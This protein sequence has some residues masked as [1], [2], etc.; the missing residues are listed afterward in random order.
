MV[1]L[2]YA[3]AHSLN[4]ATVRLAVKL[5]LG[6]VVKTLHALGVTDKLPA[7]PSLALG[8]A[9]LSPLTMTQVYQ[10][11]AAGGFRSPL[12][13]IRAVTTQ[14]GRPLQ[15]YRLKAEAAADARAVYLTNTALQQV[16]KSGTARGLKRM[17]PAGMGA[18]G[19]T[20]TT[21]KLRDSW[22]AGFTSSRVAVV[23][24]GRDDNTPAGLTG[25]QGARSSRS[26]G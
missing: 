2:D 26:G 3:L 15:R 9:T 22:F 5:G 4:V 6:K 24:V 12:R 25:A 16:V 1:A 11:L 23:W 17:L 18:A 20:G 8:S 21:N 7:Y 19:K 10:T 13:A 14:D